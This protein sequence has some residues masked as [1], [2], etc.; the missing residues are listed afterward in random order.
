[1]QSTFKSPFADPTGAPALIRRLVKEHAVANWRRYLLAFWLM[2][3]AA[4]LTAAS[5]SL[6][7]RLV[8]EAYH[9][10]NLTHL[11]LVCCLIMVMSVVKGLATYGSAV[12]LARVNNRIVADNER[13]MFDKL[14]NESLG[15]FANTHSSEFMARLTTGAAAASQTLTLLITAVGRDFLLLV[16]LVSVMIMQD[17]VMSLFTFVIAPPLVIVMRQLV[18]RARTVILKKYTS[19][20]ATLETLQEAL[21]GIRIVKAFTLEDTMR[22]R[23]HASIS[24]VQA[25]ADKM[26]RVSNRS[27]PVMEALA[28]LAIGAA[29]LYGG[30]RVIATGAKPGEF[31]AFLAAF[32]LAYEP[33]KRLARLNF[34][35]SHTLLGVR[36]YYELIDSPATEPNEDAK[37][38]LALSTARVEFADVRF[39]YR[40][41][42]P[43][44]KGI[45]FVA[46][47]G[48]VTALVGPSGGG[49]ST[50]LNLILRF[51]EI[52]GGAIVVDGQ[53]IAAVSRRSLRE[54]IS[55]VGQDVFLF[56][57]TVRD[58]IAF[59]KPGTTED[60]VIAAAKAAHAHEF[61]MIFPLGYDTPVGERG[62]QLSGG[63]RQRIAVARALLRNAPIVLL[64]EATA[65][66]DSESE[67]LVQDAIAHLCQGRTTIVV[68][69]R[70]HT[71]THSDRI[72]VIED[73]QIVESG[74]HD[75]L[76]RRNARY[77]SFYRLQLREQSPPEPVAI[78]SSA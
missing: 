34:D 53:N 40:P 12:Q 73:G 32:L 41:G 31:V 44:L 36:L 56:R 28:G 72:I 78:A 68:A 21:Q 23:V 57:G 25:A 3:L 45:S 22:T 47:P 74:R 14:L 75:E 65:S 16:F 11:V 71:I 46:E 5:A 15:Y 17:P 54:Q 43:V 64:D 55:Y 29:M 6:F 42:E 69:H 61:V 24:D 48:R 62:L 58:N 35:L 1:M 39:A 8:N 76:L 19:G 59:G 49:K 63:Q 38:P 26:A 7:G 20:V 70:L 37:P 66:L 60:E 51:Y 50:V 67:R 9:R 2:V 10:K 27:S 52:D 18:R 77:A 33:G 13:R 4:A 30:Y